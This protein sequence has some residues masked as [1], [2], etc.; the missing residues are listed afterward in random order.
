MGLNKED[1]VKRINGY[2]QRSDSHPRLVNV[3]NPD[4]MNF[5]CRNFSIG[6]NVFKSVSDFTLKGESLSEDVLHNF[7]GGAKGV[8]FLTGITSYY[9]LLGDKKLQDFINGIVGMSLY[10]L[11]LIVICYQ[12]E[13]F[14]S[15]TD[16]RYSQFFYMVDGPK[17]PLP[18]IVLIKAKMPLAVK[19]AVADGVQSIAEFVERCSDSNLFVHTNKRKDSYPDSLYPINELRDSYDALCIIDDTTAQLKKDYGTEE[20]WQRSL[21]E[22]A[23]HGSW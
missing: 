9:R 11:H 15:K 19:E 1:T 14:L 13:E 12:C 3:N 21:A 7:L 6:D 2:L 17:A 16:K 23:K 5:I 22:V 10:N 18:Q 4:D 20:D 8:V